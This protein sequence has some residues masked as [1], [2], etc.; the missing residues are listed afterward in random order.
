MAH[1][2]SWIESS[3]AKTILEL[4]Q[5]VDPDEK[6]V[7]FSYFTTFLKY[8]ATVLDR[9]RIT[10][11]LFT[12]ELSANRRDDV[13]QRF[14][15]RAQPQVL[16]A[17]ITTCGVGINLTRATHCIIADPSWNPGVEEQAMN[18]IHRI[19]QS[20][21]VTIT[22]LLC[23]GTVDEEVDKLA[24]FKKGLSESY[25]FQDGKGSSSKRLG[26]E[27]LMALFTRDDVKRV[28]AAAATQ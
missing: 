14:S 16:L 2:A 3:K 5:G 22:R 24:E 18:R 25:C 12:G 1:H 9:H 27:E 26:R 7:V 19:G 8:F 28:A 15:R 10:N 13:I 21:P 6:V 4:I 17:S 20:R 11:M 23:P